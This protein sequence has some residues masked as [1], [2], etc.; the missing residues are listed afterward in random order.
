[1]YDEDDIIDLILSGKIESLNEKEDDDNTLD[2][3]SLNSESKNKKENLTPILYSQKNKEEQK[4][5]SDKSLKEIKNEKENESKNKNVEKIFE[6]K[7]EEI[8]KKKKIEE[9]KKIEEFFPQFK[10]PLDFVKYLEI[11][12]VDKDILNEMQ[13]FILESHLKKDNKY[14]VS[15]INALLQINKEIAEID[16]KLMYAK[17]DLILFYTK[18]GNILLFSLKGQN[19]EKSIVPKN[20]KNTHINCIDITDDL[21]EIVCGYQDGTIAVINR[22]SGDTKYT[23]N[24]IHKD[25]ACIEL[26]IFKKD[27]EKNELY[28]VSSGADGQVFY[29]ILKIG[30]FWRLNSEQIMQKNDLP[31]FLIKYILNNDLSENYVILGSIEEIYLH[32]IEPSIDKLFSIK[33]PNFIKNSTA[34]DTQ[35]GMG[36]L[37]E[38]MMYEKKNDN[39][40]LLLIISWANIIY[41][42]QLKKNK[43]KKITNYIM[44]LEIILIKIIYLKLAL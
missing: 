40:N 4:D 11:D 22:Q 23:N 41:F 39:N 18:N 3:H 25:C 44:K 17:K 8:S 2:K 37:P 20:I 36:F 29:N 30:F 9:P 24:K 42:Y 28:F 1:M 14:E 15:E 21:Q 13:N 7:N 5:T 16:I 38:R 34:P 35:A 33:K 12:R 43:E 32:C 6:I 19:F 27:K 10:N 26:K 31:I